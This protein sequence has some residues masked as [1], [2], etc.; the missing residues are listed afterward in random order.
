MPGEHAVTKPPP[1]EPA[2]VILAGD[3]LKW[4][5]PK[6]GRFPRQ[7]RHGLGSRIEAAHLEV[8]EGLVE[9]QYTRGAGR[10][11]ALEFANRRLQ[12]ARHL[13]RLAH[14]MTLLSEKSYLHAAT[15]QVELGVQVGAWR[16]ASGIMGNSSGNSA[17]PHT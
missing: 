12:V 8:L 6:V 9:A 13:L 1:S 3:L 17:I 11:E 2:A 15:M 16:K 14:E 10:G 5:I 7:V 4:I